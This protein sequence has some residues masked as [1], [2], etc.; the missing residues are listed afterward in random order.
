MMHLLVL[1]FYIWD[2]A[3]NFFNQGGKEMMISKKI[4][5]TA[6]IFLTAV[7]LTVGATGSAFGA[8]T[9]VLT[10]TFTSTSDDILVWD[11]QPLPEGQ[12]LNVPVDNQW[13]IAVSPAG[14]ASLKDGVMQVKTPYVGNVNFKIGGLD[15]SAGLYGLLTVDIFHPDAV[16]PDY[17]I[18]LAGVTV[19]EF[20]THRTGKSLSYSFNATDNAAMFAD[21]VTLKVV[22]CGIAKL[23]AFYDNIMLDIS[24]APIPI[25]T[26]VPY[27]G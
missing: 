18:V 15:T 3:Y 19:M 23:R 2:L 13:T 10:E 8:I 5:I 16:S 6:F 7:F 26:P 25:P 4:R 22:S 20:K 11:G 21:G 9:N 12:T 17:G 24:D 1:G 14:K 27:S